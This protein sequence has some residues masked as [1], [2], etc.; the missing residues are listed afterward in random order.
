M[1]RNLPTIGIL[2]DVSKI[3]QH[4]DPGNYLRGAWKIVWRALGPK[5]LKDWRG[6]F[7]YECDYAGVDGCCVAIQ[8]TDRSS[9]ERIRDS[10]LLSTEYQSVAWPPSFLE[11]ESVRALPLMD[12][13]MIDDNGNISGEKAYCSKPALDSVR[14]ELEQRHE[15]ATT[16]S[17][18]KTFLERDASNLEGKNRNKK[19][20]Q[21]IFTGFSKTSRVPVGDLNAG[22][23]GDEGRDPRCGKSSV[24]VGDLN[25]GYR[26][27]AVKKGIVEHLS[28]VLAEKVE[29]TAP[30]NYVVWAFDG[31]GFK[32]GIY[33]ND[34]EEAKKAFD[35]RRS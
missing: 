22:H 29:A 34:R 26:V 25:V 1:S 27:V 6:A 35:S 11:D 13:G 28:I 2:F 32:S 3:E 24:A 7:L 4:V 8:S 10:L 14:K 16:I 33:E 5:R 15:A 17:H 21:K 12:A 30:T 19:W 18:K 31:T 23:S 9:L 20:W